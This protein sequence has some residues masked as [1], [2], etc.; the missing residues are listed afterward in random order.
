MLSIQLFNMTNFKYMKIKLK[1]EFMKSKCDLYQFN[2]KSVSTTMIDFTLFSL[3]SFGGHLMGNSLSICGIFDW[4]QIYD[5]RAVW[6]VHEYE[7]HMSSH[8]S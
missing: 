6:V 1:W 5:C 4:R 8:C 7:R 2:L 3:L